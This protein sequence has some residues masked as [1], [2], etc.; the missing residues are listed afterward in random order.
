MKKP[1]PDTRASKTSKVSYG[2]ADAYITTGFYGDGQPGEVFVKVSKA[3]S[4]MST[5][6]EVAGR[7]A[8]E[9]LQNGVPAQELISIWENVNGEGGDLYAKMAKCLREHTSLMGGMID[10]GNQ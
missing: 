10:K 3:G 9:M 8:S 2:A 1:L 6:F 7:L 4:F 5:T